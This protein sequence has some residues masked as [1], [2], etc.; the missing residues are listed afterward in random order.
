[1][2]SALGTVPVTMAAP[3]IR[4]AIDAG[5]IDGLLTVD[6]VLAAHNLVPPTTWSR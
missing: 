1:M 2:I 3:D 5:E 4:T 6:A